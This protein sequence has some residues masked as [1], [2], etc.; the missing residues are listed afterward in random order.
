V[1]GLR[2]KCPR[3]GTPLKR[4]KVGGV[5]TDVCEDCGGLWLDRLEL[6]RFEAPDSVLG[7]ALA[8]H[9]EQ[10]AL[11]IIDAAVRL[12]CPR[13]PDVVMRKRRYG[14]EVPVAIDECPE[15]GGIW[16][17]ADELVQIRTL[18]AKP[19]E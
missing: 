13:H 8:A 4:L 3:T 17:D 1:D 14:R 9:L 18:R 15:C 11:V 10:F 19:A 2:L 16:L 12:R 7:A 5:E 6:G